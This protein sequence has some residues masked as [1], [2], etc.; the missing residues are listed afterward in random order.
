MKLFGSL[1]EV[2]G[3]VFRK[4]S[5][6]ITVRPNQ[7]TTY[8]A[9][10]DVQ[11][12]PGDAAHVLTSA[13]STQTL[14]NKSI[15]ADTN[16]ITNI[17]DADIKAAAAINATKIGNG[18]VD[19]TELSLL[20]GLTGAIVTDSSTTTLTNK[21]IDGDNNTVQDL[22]ITS[23]KTVL[24]DAN[25]VLR[26]DASGVPQSGNVLPNTSEL[27]TLDATQSLSNKTLG[28]TNSIVNPAA[29]EVIDN[30]FVIKDN[31][32]TSKQMKF[33]IA[34]F[35]AATLRTITFQDAA[36][37]VTLNDATQVLTNK[38]INGGTASNTSRLTV[39]KASSAT[40]AGLTRKE[41]TLV[42]DTTLGKFLQDNGSALTA[43]GSGSGTG[44][45]NA[46][47]NPSVADATTGWTNGTSHTLT[48]VTSGSPLDPV[49]STALS[50]AATTTAT[51][52][53]TSG[54]Y[55]TIST[56]PTGLRNMKVKVEFYF[57]TEASQTWAV[58]VWQSSTRKAL[59]TD[60][61]GATLLPSGVTGKFIAF[62]DT[63]SSTSY[64][65]NLTR[66]AGS[67]TATLI[68]TNVVVGPDVRS[69][70]AVI[71]DWSTETVTYT[72]IGTVSNAS[73]VKRRVGN[74][75]EYRGIVTAGTPTAALFSISMP[76]GLTIASSS[77]PTSNTTS[78][79][80]PVVGSMG[81][82]SGT[83]S[84]ATHLVTATGTSTSFIYSGHRISANNAII[85]P[86]NGNS[87]VSAGDVLS[88][89]L[90]VPVAE[91]TGSGTVNLGQNDV[92]YVFSTDTSNTT[93]SSS[94]GYGPQGSLF[95]QS[96]VASASIDKIVQFTTPIGISDQVVLEVSSDSG[97]TW[98]P[99]T[100]TTDDLDVQP[101]QRQTTGINYGVY[102]TPTSATQARV[103][104]GKYKRESGGAFGSAGSDWGTQT[105][106]R[107]RVKKIKAGAAVGFGIVSQDSSGLMPSTNTNLD[108]ASATRLGLKA[109]SHGTSYNGGNAPTITLTAGGGTLSSVQQGDFIPY[110]M[111]DGQWRMRFNIAV[112]LSS[113]ARTTTVLAINGIL[114]T[115][116]TGNSPH[117]AVSCWA[118]T[119]Y[120]D[121]AA[122]QNTN[123][124]EANYP[125]T[126]TNRIAFSGDLRLN[127]KP[128]WAY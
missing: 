34:A 115:A 6:E 10:R 35:S 5:Q 36:G 126:A 65:V 103:R 20:N 117:Y 127:A 53:S 95:P 3:L 128:T 119:S 93:A 37:T 92:E 114:F 71:G 58:S 76:S 30:V 98:S 85:T 83:Q 111:Q 73:A 51:E 74:M 38:D 122:L 45:I 16:T 68:A 96:A 17:E 69:S 12:P 52:S 2:I 40:L 121:A 112:S 78:N 22:A 105:T 70:S 64:T 79:P 26:R 87:L 82:T 49:I 21:T 19:N 107:W 72:G 29:L 13:N 1:K 94:F 43:L 99:L 77:L 118:G 88:W 39:P 59:S 102:V 109:Y 32:D 67:G 27:V 75:L 90:Q 81:D 101:Y 124:L 23:L 54:E 9:A 4:N 84:T 63:D 86:Q 33:D 116:T 8:T 61:S 123:T 55:Y 97:A 24:G 15:D 28:S 125:S 100:A 7:S 42:Y 56:M 41:A 108:N 50:I 120:V 62:F 91:W 57:T 18:D 47:L 80:G 25:K 31:V 44:E 110:Q 46:V 106:R 113:T 11:L 60:S 66:T 48:R 14:T 89:S 104:F